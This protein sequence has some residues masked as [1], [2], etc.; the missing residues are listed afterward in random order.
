MDQLRVGLVGGGPWARSVH[1]PALAAHPG[2]ELAGV[3]TRRPEP[4]RE[5]VAQ[6]GGTA[7]AEVEELF[8]AVDAVAFAVPPAVQGALV[9]AAAARGKHL[10]LDKPLADT[11]PA[12]ERAAAAVAEAG[13][14]STTV[15]TLRFHPPVRAWL[16][17][18]P[19]GP[20]DADTTATARWLSGA[21]LG[22]PYAASAWRAERGALLDIGP[23][24]VDLLDAAL[25]EVVDVEFAHVGEP[26][27]WR[28]GLRHVGGARSTLTLSL[29]LPVDPTEMEVTA[30][31]SIGRHVL[32]E[33]PAD[34]TAS[35][36]VLL[37]ELLKAVAT[38][39]VDGPHTAAR[40]LHVQRVL[41]RAEELARR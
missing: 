34:A 41:A 39:L 17:G 24:L 38:G 1:A 28:V 26:D 21:L 12:A 3:W 7:F 9:P 20:A 37:D 13:V 30:F 35:Y 27:L 4:A 6:H 36:A 22:G 16:A 10:I 33:R 32:T 25:G 19:D 5:I 29:A 15:F 8:E 2:V 18:L 23:H 14:C 40:S 11:L 31:G